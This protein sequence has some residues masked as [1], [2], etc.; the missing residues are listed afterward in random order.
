MAMMTTLA[1]SKPISLLSD[2][3]VPPILPLDHHIINKYAIAK[4]PEKNSFAWTD[5]TPSINITDPK[6]MYRRA[7]V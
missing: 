1:I 7:M 3:N 6:L 2:D 4:S 5:P